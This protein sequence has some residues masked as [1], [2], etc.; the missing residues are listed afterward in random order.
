[1]LPEGRLLIVH[2][3]HVLLLH[4]ICAMILLL[5][6]CL[7]E[8]SPSIFQTLSVSEPEFRVYHAL[9]LLLMIILLI[10]KAVSILVQVLELV[11]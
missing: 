1:M 3:L 8:I 7:G 4:R 10:L 6:F 9:R 11:G 5:V 2:A